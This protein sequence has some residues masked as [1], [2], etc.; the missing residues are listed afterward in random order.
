MKVIEVRVVVPGDGGGG[1]VALAIYRCRK[2]VIA[3]INVSVDVM[4]LD[5]IARR[6]REELFD[7]GKTISRHMGYE[8]PYPHIGNS[9]Q[10]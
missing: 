8:G 5:E 9:A 4:R 1:K 3:A 10:E 2:A 7:K 6:A